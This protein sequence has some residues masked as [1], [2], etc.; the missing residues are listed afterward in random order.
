MKAT[1]THLFGRIA[2]VSFLGL[3]TLSPAYCRASATGLSSEGNAACTQT[4]ASFPVDA[5]GSA[6][7][8]T[9]TREIRERVYVQ[10]DKDF[11]LAGETLWLKMYVTDP[12]GRLIDFSRI[13]YAE[14]LG[15]KGA[16]AQVKLALAGGSG[17]GKFILPPTL[18]SDSYRLT[19]Y[20]RHMRN[21]GEAVY[22]TKTIRVYN[23]W[24]TSSDDRI[25]EVTAPDTGAALVTQ[26]TPHVPATPPIRDIS[27]ASRPTGGQATPDN[28]KAGESSSLLPPPL[29]VLSASA[30]SAL[31]IATD[32]VTYPIRSRVHIRLEGIPPGTDLALSI[33]RI[34]SLPPGEPSGLGYWY[35]QLAGLPRLPLADT[36][37]P[38]YEGAVVTGRILPAT[39]TGESAGAESAAAVPLPQSLS[40]TLAVPG[41]RP[42]LFDG[43]I[44]AMGRVSFYTDALCG[45][46]EVIAVAE[47]PGPA[48]YRIDLETGF[49]SHAPVKMP[50]LQLYKRN[51]AA[52]LAHSMALQ[53]QYL[54]PLDGL[55]AAATAALQG[56]TTVAVEEQTASPAAEGLPQRNLFGK[57]GPNSPPAG[58]NTGLEAQRKAIEAFGYASRFVPSRSYRLDEYV[59]FRTVEQTFTEFIQG[60]VI[61]KIGNQPRFCVRKEEKQGFNDGNTLVLLDGIPL[62]DHQTLIDYNP[63]RLSRIDIYQGTYVFGNRMYEGMIAFYTPRHRFPDLRLPSG[64]QLLDY[65]GTAAVESLEGVAYPSDSLR[66]SRRPDFRHTLYWNPSLKNAAPDWELDCY[67]SDF[68]GSY[69]IS[70]EGVSPQGQPV[71][72]RHL[73]HI[74]D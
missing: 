41:D 19:G 47:H 4:E 46:H 67:A 61:R 69:L 57:K 38:E 31:R 65:K 20:T 11:Y 15:A 17:W 6:P 25:E 66:A 50:P 73:I 32:R 72:G 62:A 45:V 14:L 44:D 13:G 42:R 7:K 37:L 56:T 43:Q 74:Q 29:P 49:A 22:F 27:D 1:Y 3:P 64:T 71:C 59:R 35:T 55:Q 24:T 54:F 30:A 23:A 21:E 51:E 28:E 58:G 10:T 60:V 70:V 9:A 52:L 33:V 48:A 18:P 5:K 68:E 8:D 34:D 12:A 39:G 40:A 2:L 63:Y 53:S 26:S 36:Y 16:E